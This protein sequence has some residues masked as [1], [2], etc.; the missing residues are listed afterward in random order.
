M[1]KRCSEEQIISFLK[2]AEVGMLVVDLWRKHR[3]SHALD[4][5]WQPKWGGREVSMPNAQVMGRGE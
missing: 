4:C 2:D 3:F 1:E 5:K